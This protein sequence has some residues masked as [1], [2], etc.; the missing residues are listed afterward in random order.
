MNAENYRVRCFFHAHICEKDAQTGLNTCLRVFF[1]LSGG[2]GCRSPPQPLFAEYADRRYGAW[3]TKLFFSRFL[4]PL[5][6]KRDMLTVVVVKGEEDYHPL[7][8]LRKEVRR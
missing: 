6:P 2:K 5:F 4:L 1:C 7:S 3:N 8:R